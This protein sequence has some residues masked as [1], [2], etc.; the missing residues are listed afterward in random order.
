MTVY[1]FVARSIPQTRSGEIVAPEMKLIH[2]GHGRNEEEAHAAKIQSKLGEIPFFDIDVPDDITVEE[3]EGLTDQ[4]LMLLG[5]PIVLLNSVLRS[6]TNEAVPK[7]M[8]D[9][10]RLNLHEMLQARWA[11]FIT[12]EAKGAPVRITFPSRDPSSST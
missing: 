7:R 9:K 1:T 8:I 10:I 5:D 4:C 11:T 12:L 3:V 2:Y 6:V